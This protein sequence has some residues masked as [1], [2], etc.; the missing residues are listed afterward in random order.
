MWV[1]V[2]AVLQ[3]IECGENVAEVR[4]GDGVVAGYLVKSAVKEGEGAVS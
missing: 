4:K 2:F 3:G 1:V